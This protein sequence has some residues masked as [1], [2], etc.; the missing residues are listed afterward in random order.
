LNNNKDVVAL[1]DHLFLHQVSTV[2]LWDRV[3]C[4]QHLLAHTIQDLSTHFPLQSKNHH[5]WHSGH[6]VIVEN[7]K[8]RREIV[9]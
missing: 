2:T 5:W 9:S 3:L 8:L 1:S 6:L 4:A 7:N